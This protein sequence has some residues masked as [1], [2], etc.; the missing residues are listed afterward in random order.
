[1]FDMIKCSLKLNQTCIPRKF[2][3]PFL[4]IIGFNLLKYFCCFFSF[5]IMSLSPFCCQCST[6]F[7]EWIGMYSLPFKF[8]DNIVKNWY[9]F[10]LKY[11]AKFTSEVI[12]AWWLFC[13]KVFNHKVNLFNKY[14]TKQVCDWSN[15]AQDSTIKLSISSGVKFD[16]FVFEETY[17]FHL[18]SQIYWYKVVITV[19]YYTLWISVKSI[20]VSPFCSL[21]LVIVSFF[22]PDQ[23]SYLGLYIL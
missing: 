1:M 2:V 12:W 3:L 7:I 10:F 18:S 16:S 22:Y 23:F 14:R 6:D 9:Y 5:L 15:I 20:V 11:L 4:Y 8:L 13:G 21:K 19:P 17:P